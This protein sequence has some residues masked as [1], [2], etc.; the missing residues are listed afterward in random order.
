MNKKNIITAVLVALVVGTMLNVINSYDVFLDGNF[1]TRNSIKV[2]L[3]YMTPFF[4]S[5]YSSV[6]ATKQQTVKID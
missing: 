1:S 6:R 2:I 4:V 3:T 5:L